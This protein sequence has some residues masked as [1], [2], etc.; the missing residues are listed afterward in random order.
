MAVEGRGKSRRV[1]GKIPSGEICGGIRIRL[2]SGYAG[3][4]S[5]VSSN[6][7]NVL[8]STDV[9]DDHPA[10]SENAQ[11]YRLPQLLASSDQMGRLGADCL[12]LEA[13][14][15]W[16]QLIGARPKQQALILHRSHWFSL[17]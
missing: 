10:S 15:K 12:E 17:N 5:R 9:R 4:Q 8:Q 3:I 16:Q 11:S 6:R 13:Q 2:I 14:N 7:R 1:A